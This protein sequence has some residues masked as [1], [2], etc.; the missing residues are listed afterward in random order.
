MLDFALLFAN[1]WKTQRKSKGVVKRGVTRVVTPGTLIDESLLDESK[2][3]LLGA[4]HFKNGTVSIALT[5]LS[6]GRFELHQCEAHRVG[7]VLQRLGL[8]EVIIDE[9][10]EFLA[11]AA[12]RFGV[13]ITTRPSWMFLIDEGTALL[14]KQ[15][16]VTTV[17]GFGL[18]ADDER[19]RSGRR[20]TRIRKT[21]TSAT[22]RIKPFENSNH[23]K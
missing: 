6:T 11:G 18:Q 12:S 5:E 17:E 13:S 2:S 10:D 22:W 19:I 14:T 21:N 8:S 20:T 7:D 15:F 16:G 3:N 4:M 9:D 1:N 23:S